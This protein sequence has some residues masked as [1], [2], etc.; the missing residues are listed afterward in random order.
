MDVSN[1]LKPIF[2]VRSE[3]AN[4]QFVWKPTEFRHQTDICCFN[5]TCSGGKGGP[6][7]S[8]SW[9]LV[10]DLYPAAG[11]WAAT[12]SCS[13][14]SDSSSRCWAIILSSVEESL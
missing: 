9:E 2:W 5:R 12:R 1:L 11:I 3:C 7:P 10:L 8:E 4:I 14:C 13:R 6:L